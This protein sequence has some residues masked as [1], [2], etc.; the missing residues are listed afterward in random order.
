MSLGT[1]TVAAI[2]GRAGDSMRLPVDVLTGFLG[3]GKTTLLSRLLRE[4]SFARTAVI[5]NEFGEV[6]IDHDLVETSDEQFVQLTTGCLCCRIRSDLVETLLE[7]ARR[8]TQGEVPPFERVVI[9]TSGLADPAPILQALMLDPAVAQSYRSGSVITT[10]DALLAERTLD[11]QPTA[12]RQV[13][14]ADALV[15]TKTDL[16]AGGSVSLHAL[17]RAL[18]PDAPIQ[19]TRAGADDAGAIW[20]TAAA[21]VPPW[22]VARTAEDSAHGDHLG[23]VARW[24]LVRERPLPAA[25]LTLFLEALAEHCGERLLRVK[26]IVEVAGEPERPVVVQGVQHVFHP[27]QWLERW[28]SEDRRSRLVFIGEDVPGE[29]I[30][31][32]LD[33]LEAEVVALESAIAAG[34]AA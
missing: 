3:S 11:A 12:R 1:T 5:V 31:A 8:R 30:G 4:P 28:P 17:L 29:W 26:G 6:G 18:N 25:V 34:A 20:A 16:D 24:I 10:V 32:L 22:R 2:S 23:R 21:A 9:E 7:L 27:L 19:S 14:L 13:A 33:S 15:I